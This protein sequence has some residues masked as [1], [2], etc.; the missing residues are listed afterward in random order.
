MARSTFV[1]FRTTPAE[2]SRW[3]IAAASSGMSLSAWLRSLADIAA[4]TGA[5]PGDV[6][7]ELVAL[8]RDLNA[9]IGNNINQIAH[10]LNADRIA[11]NPAS[12][13][14]A[15]LRQMADDLARIRGAIESLMGSRAP[16]APRTKRRAENQ[17]QVSAPAED[18]RAAISKLSAICQQATDELSDAEAISDSVAQG[19]G[20]IDALLGRITAA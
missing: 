11:G 2:E 18:G 1:K 6:R 13:S 16:T 9:G 12:S 14:E 10:A 5:N 3:R 8:R 19:L 20:F 4:A 15:A 17:L 7:A